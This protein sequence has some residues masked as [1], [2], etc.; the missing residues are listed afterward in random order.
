MNGQL[1][2][3]DSD[4]LPKDHIERCETITNSGS[5]CWGGWLSGASRSRRSV[6]LLSERRRVGHDFDVEAAVLD[7]RGHPRRADLVCG[8]W[9]GTSEHQNRRA[10]GHGGRPGALHDTRPDWSLSSNVVDAQ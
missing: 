5:G 9:T 10:D 6:Q 4:A 1:V 3:L 2:E 7:E 8:G